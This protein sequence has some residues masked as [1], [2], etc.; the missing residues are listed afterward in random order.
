[1]IHEAL[2][3]RSIKKN[4]SLSLIWPVTT[5]IISVK[6]IF[7]TFFSRQK[8]FSDFFAVNE[9]EVLLTDLIF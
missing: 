7:R 9:Y 1:M 4:D 3:I 2:N 6:N 8:I 5:D